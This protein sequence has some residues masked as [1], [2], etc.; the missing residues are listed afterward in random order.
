[1]PCH[2]CDVF[3]CVTI[4]S[5]C[6]TLHHFMLAPRVKK[7]AHLTIRLSSDMKRDLKDAAAQLDR[8]RNWLVIH[9]LDKWLKARHRKS[10]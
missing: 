8:S 9:I 7:D 1:M 6:A 3:Q 10:K 2:C 4:G 5:L